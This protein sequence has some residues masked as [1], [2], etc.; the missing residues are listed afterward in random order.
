[1]A[2]STN[3]TAELQVILDRWRAGNASTATVFE[4][5][6]ARF[7]AI[8]RKMLRMYPSVRAKEETDDVWHG[9]SV[10]LARALAEVKPATVRALTGLAVEQIRRELL[11]LA[12]SY[13][14]RP[15]VT[16][17]DLSHVDDSEPDRDIDR[18]AA[19]HEEVGRLPE[20]VKEAFE[21]VYY[22]GLTQFE[23][24]RIIGTSD[25]TVRSHW[26]AAKLLLID[27]FLE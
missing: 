27:V 11:D 1:V 24:A 25:R 14:R 7:R 26:K 20:S 2:I 15:V 16:A 8:A 10:R 5:A 6:D 3:Q 9:A 17:G 21:L 12:R 13:R 19:F 22:G 4:R 23:A 18:W